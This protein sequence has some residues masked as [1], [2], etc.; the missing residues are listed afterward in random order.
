M[1]NSPKIT[2]L[3]NSEQNSKIKSL[4]NEQII[5]STIYPINFCQTENWAKFWTKINNKSHKIVVFDNIQ[6]YIYPWQFGQ[7]FAYIPKLR[8]KNLEQW[9]NLLDF[10]ANL[11]QKE[12]FTNSSEVQK[13]KNLVFLKI[14]FDIVSLSKIC[15]EL[16]TEITVWQSQ[17]P[18]LYEFPIDQ[19]LAETNQKILQ[20]LQKYSQNS[21]FKKI[22]ISPKKIQYLQSTTII[23]PVL[24]NLNEESSN[25]QIKLETVKT[26]N[27][28]ANFDTEKITEQTLD[29]GKKLNNQKSLNNSHNPNFEVLNDFYQK[30]PE[31]WADFS[32]RVRRYTRK[33]LKELEQNKFHI[34]IEKTQKTWQDF[35]NLHL[36]TSQRQNFPTQSAEYLRELFWQEFTRIIIIKDEKGEVQSVFFGILQDNLKIEKQLERQINSQNLENNSQKILTYLLGGNSQTALTNHTQYLLQL[37]A[38]WL[39]AKEKCEFYDMGGW[40]FGT[41][42]SEFKNGYRG[43]LQTFF[44]PF[45]F[46][47]KPNSYNLTNFAINFAKKIRNLQK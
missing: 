22:Q 15:P 4:E 23:L 36:Q 29:F 13:V 14:D 30:S 40:E 17:N 46:V 5:S 16:Q 8:L 42:Y 27:L 47:L 24:T 31:L 3:Q 18:E 43:N 35:Y 25:P 37:A 21:K 19:K 11:D 32:P 1:S 7:F 34:Q 26:S 33:I 41:G 2:D 38:L 44:G 39:C 28:E 6:I 10:V 20:S 45:D 9:K 12:N